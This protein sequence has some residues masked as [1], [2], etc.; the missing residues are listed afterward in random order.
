MMD[1]I[2]GGE[3]LFGLVFMD[4]NVSYV[5]VIEECLNECYIDF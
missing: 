5:K 4:W 1:F 3:Y 2:L